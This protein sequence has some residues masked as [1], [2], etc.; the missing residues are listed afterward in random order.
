LI[1][2]EIQIDMFC[3]EGVL[4]RHGLLNKWHQFRGRYDEE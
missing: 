1:L 4:E 3:L 2:D